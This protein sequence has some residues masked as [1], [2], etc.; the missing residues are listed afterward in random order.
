MH[1]AGI[2]V[3]RD[4]QTPLHRQLA[5]AFRDAILSGKLAPGDRVLSS[6]ELQTHLGLSRNTIVDA[7]DQLHSEGYLVTVRGVGTFVAEHSAGRI[8]EIG[9]AAGEPLLPTPLADAHAAAAPFASNTDDNRAFRHGVPALDLFAATQFKRC[10][11]SSDWTVQMLGYP[12]PQGYEPLREAISRRLRQ[13]RGVAC[14]ADQVFIINGAQAALSLVVRLL[15]RKGDRTIFEE[16]GYLGVRAVLLAHGARI[17]PAPV[18]RDGIDPS[19]FARRAASLVYVT[20][21]HQY[22]TGAVLTLQR[23]LALLEWTHRN[24]AWIVED[25]YDSEFNYTGRVVPALHGLAQGQRVLY[26][27]TFSKVLSPA[28]RIAYIVVPPELK[29][30]F[31]AVQR[32]EGGGPNAFVQAALARF[33]DEGHLGRHIAKMRKIYDERRRFIGSAL[34]AASDAFRV[35]DS[36]AGLHFVVDLPNNIR[37]AQVS[38]RAERQGIVVPPLSLYY[39]GKPTRN[40]LVVGFAATSIARARDAVAVLKRSVSPA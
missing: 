6:R 2:L 1:G 8:A 10:F 26:L 28:L 5:E 13:T 29:D 39:L 40:G 17:V 12:D 3:D 23:R 14:G 36:R 34:S 19:T 16:P 21:S 9:T 37:D 15:L 11:R 27:G 32:V 33:M 18:D 7:L 30:A 4:S 20:P 31:L 22:P 24:G 38:E 25:D 35:R